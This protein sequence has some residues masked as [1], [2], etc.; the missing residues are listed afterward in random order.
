MAE[1]PF[2]FTWCYE[3]T[4][5]D[6]E[7]CLVLVIGEPEDVPP[8]D[9]DIS[10]ILSDKTIAIKPID[11]VSQPDAD[12]YH[13]KLA[14]AP[15]ILADPSA[16]AVE[17]TDWL[18]SAESTGDGDYIYLL[19]TSAETYLNPDDTIKIILDGVAAQSEVASD[20]VELSTTITG[21]AEQLL[22]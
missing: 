9:I 3:E 14:F 4:E 10:N 22:M 12:N 16:I 18:V 8:L 7:Q 11:G 1:M 2:G 17:S 21:V 20:S 13:F 19:W 15:G 5:D 6:D